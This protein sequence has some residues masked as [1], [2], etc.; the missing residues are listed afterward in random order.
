MIL[1]SCLLFVTCFV[2]FVFVWSLFG[3]R[4]LVVTPFL[5]FSTF[6]MAW[7]WPATVY[8]QWVGTATAFPSILVGLA[9]LAF[10]LG[11]CWSMRMVKAPSQ[12]A[13]EF[14][15]T[16]FDARHSTIAY[17]GVILSAVAVLFGLA[18]YLYHGFPPIVDM[19]RLTLSGESHDSAVSSLSQARYEYSKGQYF[20]ETYRGAGLIQSIQ[21]IGWAYVSLVGLFL[22]A[23]SRNKM[24]L[25]VFFPLTL[26]S[27]V[28]VGG[29][30]QRFSMGVL[31]L[32]FI[33]GYS[34]FRKVS[35]RQVAGLVGISV[36]FLFLIVPLSSQTIGG[37]GWH[38][39]VAKSVDRAVQ[40]ICL[41]NGEHSIEVIHYIDTGVLEHG[42]GRIHLQKVIS[43]LPG[44]AYGV[45]FSSEVQNVRG[46][47]ARTA[48]ASM[49]YYAVLY[50]DFGVLGPLLGYFLIGILAAAAQWLFLSRE[51]YILTAPWI[52]IGT[53][54]FSELS[55]G[56]SVSM[57]AS[58]VVLFCV[59]CS[60]EFGARVID[61]CG[62]RQLAASDR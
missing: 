55:V 40:R 29:I 53:V 7:S 26:L 34:L 1:L 18:F 11:Y 24:W 35:V 37:S 49:N 42:Y 17:L 10:L 61:S 45:P 52:V 51:K 8:A 2:A 60:F 56:S 3:R 36:A 30:G 57:I 25:F 62:Q 4:S 39:S 15:D 28:F 38:G 32:E 50:A 22:Y 47:K 19:L 48:F 21:D 43:A 59:Y 54:L 6:E 33:A 20:G 14:R 23:C 46:G 13:I 41:G 44:V 9:F 12:G 16:P 31:L 5:V 27:L 58:F